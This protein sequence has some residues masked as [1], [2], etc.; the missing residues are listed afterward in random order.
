MH[1]PHRR[2]C[3]DDLLMA[4]PDLSIPTP[5]LAALPPFSQPTHLPG[6]SPAPGLGNPHL[7]TL[8]GPLWRKTVH[9]DRRRERL[10][11]DDGDFLDLDWHGPHAAETP[12]V[13]ILHGLTG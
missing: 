5:R 7:Q 6:F 13:L 8:W 1:R 4:A 3:H 9:L 10:W 11:L 12:L 2:G